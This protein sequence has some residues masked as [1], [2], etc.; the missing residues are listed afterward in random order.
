MATNEP[1]IGQL[2]EGEANRDAIHVAI[3]PVVAAE[4]LLPGQEIGL[5][6]KTGMA[7]GYCAPSIGIVDPFLKSSV[8][9]GQ[10]FWMF[11]KP[12]TITSLRH[13]WTHPAFSTPNDR[14]YSE[15]WLREYAVMFN[16]YSKTP[17]DAFNKLVNDLR[18]GHLQCYGDDIY[19]LQQVDNS[20]LLKEHGERYL[21]IR[22]DW[23]QFTFSCA[24]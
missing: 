24:C 21:G 20:D 3:A 6:S 22:I 5:D 8:E 17:E 10:T 19:S 16:R 18:T 14:E 12:R 1:V 9:R 11:L 4:S 7:G 15:R 2:I 23:E 13:E